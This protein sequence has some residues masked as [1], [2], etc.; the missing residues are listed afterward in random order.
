MQTKEDARD[1]RLVQFDL[2]LHGIGMGEVR[3]IFTQLCLEKMYP[4]HGSATASAERVSA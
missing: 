2:Y 3:L 1:L 4:D